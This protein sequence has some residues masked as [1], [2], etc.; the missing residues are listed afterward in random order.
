MRTSKQS[1]DAGPE[2]EQ[3]LARSRRK[4]KIKIVPYERR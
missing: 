1:E 2:E 4:I 3:E